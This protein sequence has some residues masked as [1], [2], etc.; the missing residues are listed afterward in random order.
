MCDYSNYKVDVKKGP[1]ILLYDT[2]YRAMLNLKAYG[3]GKLVKE[4]RFLSH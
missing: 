2:C 3:K 1:G 4:N